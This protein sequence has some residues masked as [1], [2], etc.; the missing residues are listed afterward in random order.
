MTKICKLDQDHKKCKKEK[1]KLWIHYKPSLFQHIGTHSSLKGKV[2]KLK[3]RQFG[4]VSLFTPHK[5]PHAIIES[6]VKHYKHYSLTRAYRGDTFFW[7]LVPQ[8][9]DQIRFKFQPPVELESFKLVTGNLE[10]PS[11]RFLNTTCEIKLITENLNPSSLPTTKD[12]YLVIGGFNKF[13]VAEGSIG[14]AFGKIK[15]FRLNIGA[16][17]DNWAILSEIF[18]KAAAAAS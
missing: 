9:G 12:G 2:Q 10:H 6:P 17:N 18:F 13:G 7:G 4:R 8:Q 15:T 5:N 14:A 3:D 1:D 16:S 11:D